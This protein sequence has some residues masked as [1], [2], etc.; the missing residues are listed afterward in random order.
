M[1]LIDVLSPD[2][3]AES[4]SPWW[5]GAVAYQVYLRSFRDGD[6]DGIGDLKGLLRGLEDIAALGCDAIWLNPCY[7]SPQRD[8]GYDI[9]DYFDVDPDYGTLADFD[10][11]VREAHRLGIRVLMD[12]VAN[13]CSIEHEWF[14]AAV[15]AAP[16]SPE[17]AR[18]HFADGRGAEG[19][20]PPNNWQSVFGGPAWTRVTDAAGR[21][22]QWYLHS[23]DS[24]QPDFNW[25]SADVSLHFRR[26]LE[27]WFD[28][29]VDGFRIDVGH[30]HVKAPGLP[31]WPG[32]ETGTGGHNHAM[33]DQPGVHDIYRTWRSLGDSYPEKKYFIGEIWVP[34]IE[35]LAAYLRP[36]EMHQAFSFDLLVQPWDASR[37]RT[38]IDAGL[39]AAGSAPA[40]T[41]SN[42]DVHRTVTRYGQEQILEPTDPTDMIAA[43]RRI[44]RADLDKGTRRAAAAAALLL[45]LPG[46][47]YL[48]QGEE[49][50]LPEVFDLP[51]EARQDPIWIR[52]EGAELGRD[53][54]RV[55]IP[56][57]ATEKNFGFGESDSSWLPQP[58]WFGRYARDRAAAQPNSMLRIYEQLISLRRRF[59]AG[60]APIVWLDTE[61]PDVLAFQRAGATCVVNTGAQPFAVLAHWQTGAPVIAT[62]ATEAETV[63]PRDSAA[64]F[65]PRGG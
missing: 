45:A 40:W 6:G 30:G 8:H 41:L 25:E 44:G 26:V 10:A 33:W 56:W 22:G 31:D 15:R 63:I 18:F 23:F 24:G 54:C 3:R 19:E 14:R 50:G 52:S 58:E 55:P 65:A 57:A 36:D 34:S 27:F 37:L 16:G 61:R 21:P 32:A 11:V 59:F 42:H 62:A 38:A 12:M 5:V 46:T 9:A 35:R 1:T 20:L 39:A 60:D 28:R 2:E 48:Y 49:L 13:H 53:G 7:P 43:A 51:R 17:R 4:T 64:W 29:G 47:V